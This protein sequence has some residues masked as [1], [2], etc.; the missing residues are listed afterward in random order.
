M[1]TIV[2][3]SDTLTQDDLIVK[4]IAKVF[5]ECKVQIM[6]KTSEKLHKTQIYSNT[7]PPQLLLPPP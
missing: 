2:I 7:E 1:H 6:S 5:P 3:L 4:N